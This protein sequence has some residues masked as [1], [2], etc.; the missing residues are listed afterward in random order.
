MKW[1]DGQSTLITG[2]ASG[3][4]LAIVERFLAEGAHVTVLDRNAEGLE[5]LTARMGTVVETV[6][7]DV[8]SLTDN[9]RAVD[10][11][12]ARFG[13]LDT[14]VANAGIW[15][16]NVPLVDLPDD[17]IDE[18]FDEIFGILVKGYLLGA[19]A[20]IPA[21]VRARGS[22]VFTLSNAAFYPGGGVGLVRE[23]AYE[24]A[25]H[26]RVN[27]V[28]PGLIPSDMR[29]ARALGQDQRSV[30]ATFPAPGSPFSAPLARVPHTDE[31]ASSYVLLASAKDAATI[32]GVVIN[33]DSG[34]GVRGLRGPR[35]GD[36]LSTRFDEE[37]P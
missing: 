15:D 2:G 27:G 29:G 25:P 26:V 9:R 3:L 20:A 12:V 14:L 28:A 17:R 36:E 37:S 13:K 21:L 30:A 22:M 24:L 1:L 10:A 23:L 16:F 5:R 6:T 33:A 34:L 19:K 35:G 31:Y 32:T 7:G 18:A 11:A 4:G 8:R